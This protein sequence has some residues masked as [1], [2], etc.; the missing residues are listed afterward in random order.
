MTAMEYCIRVKGH[1]PKGWSELFE[2]MEIRP[3]EGGETLLTGMVQDQAALYGLVAKLQSLG[4]SLVAIN[5][6]V[7]TLLTSPCKDRDSPLQAN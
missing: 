7:T 1:L 6:A 3:D 5:P 2:G 4:V